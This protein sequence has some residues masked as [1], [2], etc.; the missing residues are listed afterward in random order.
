M[1]RIGTTAPDF[2]GPLHDGT[3]FSLSDW[4]GLKNVVL[5]FYL[6]NFTKG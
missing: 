3:T 6:K 2:S 1:L 4:A 5:Y